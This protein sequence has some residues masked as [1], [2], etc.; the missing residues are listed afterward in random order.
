MKF[1]YSLGGANT[2]VIREFDIDST[3]NIEKGQAVNIST[4][5][6]ISVGAI[7]G[8]I[9]IAAETHTG[10]KD[11]LNERNDGTKIRIDI[12]RNGVYS[13]PAPKFTATS[14]STTT[15]VCNSEGVTTNLA[16]SVLVLVSKGE[17]SEN[18][19]SVGS[20][21]EIQSVSV[22]GTVATLTVESGSTISEGDVYAVM[23]VYGFTGYVGDD[24]KSFSCAMKSNVTKL[25][26]VNRNTD[27]L[28][29]EVMP[30]KDF[31]N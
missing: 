31:I 26:V 25:Y 11:I 7:G 17:N 16:N 27:T 8:C 28:S 19:D 3:E 13:V 4:D 24:G 10:E 9:G 29:L 2:P 22:S 14:G 15:F 6:I 23:P 1:L 18:T 12:T 20:V 30:K 21:R 5:S